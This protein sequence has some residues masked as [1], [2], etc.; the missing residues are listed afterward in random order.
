M[1]ASA[2]CIKLI[3]DSEGLMLEPYLC[4][5]KVPTIGYG[6][7]RYEDNTPVKLTD[8]SITKE[9]AVEL[10]LATL[11][12]EYEPAVNRYVR[13]RINQNQYDALVDFAYNLGIT[14]LRTSKLLRLINDSNFTDASLE[15]KR[16]IYVDGK[17]NKG[18]LKRREL[19]RILFLS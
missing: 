14:A 19:E 5:A 13:V 3:Q 16:W 15:F 10:L 4:Q 9:R 2:N 6:S 18:L 12:R 17:K 8:K 1:K 11:A 7:T